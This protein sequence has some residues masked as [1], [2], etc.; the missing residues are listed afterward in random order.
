M[1]KYLKIT[2]EVKGDTINSKFESHGLNPYETLGLLRDYE[3]VTWLKLN[4][5]KKDVI[6]ETKVKK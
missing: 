6:T 5:E 4:R 1:E 3:K 2:M